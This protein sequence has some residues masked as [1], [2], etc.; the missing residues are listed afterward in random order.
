MKFADLGLA[1]TLLRAVEA[2][3]YHTATPVQIAAIPPVLAGRDVLACAQT[4]TGKT[5]AFALPTLQRL[6]DAPPVAGAKG[7]KI[8]VLVLSPT[9]ELARQICESFQTYGRHTHLRCAMVYGGVSQVPQVQAIRKGVD[10]LVATPGRL[11]DLLGQGLVDLGG[12]Q[13]VVLDEADRMLDMG[14]APD[15][16]R[17][18]QRVPRQRQTL[19]FSATMPGEIRKLA[20]AWLNDPVEARIAPV[21]KTTEQID[22]SVLFVDERQKLLLLTHWLTETAWTRTLVFARTKHRADKIAKSLARS[23][24]SAD[25]IHANKSQSARQKALARFKSSKPP[26]LVATDI[27]A[28]GLDIDA[29]SHVIN[30]DLPLEAASYVHRIGRTGRAG[31]TGTAILVLCRSRACPIESDRAADAQEHS[32]RRGRPAPQ[33]A[34]R[35]RDLARSRRSSRSSGGLHRRQRAANK[36]KRRPFGKPRSTSGS[37]QPQHGSSGSGGSGSSSGSGGSGQGGAGWRGRKRRRPA[38]AHAASGGGRS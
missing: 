10:V 18:V 19:L 36:S 22:E 24:I 3:G 11:V 29:V 30:F 25:A 17:I 5:A 20:N 15:L 33:D 8:R 12:V 28:R 26:V 38:Q 7:R 37:T 21:A 9:R 14:F 27:A 34:R 16:N 6:A 35:H 23:G 13:V 2:E 1:E 32:G 4:G 31:A